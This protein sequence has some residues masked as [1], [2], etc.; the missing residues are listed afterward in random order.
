MVVSGGR[1]MDT[2]GAVLRSLDKNLSEQNCV[3]EL[4]SEG[5]QRGQ[6]IIVFCSSR[7][8]CEAT[9]RMLGEKADDVFRSSHAMSDDVPPVPIDFGITHQGCTHTL[10]TLRQERIACVRRLEEKCRE[11]GCAL[12]VAQD[13]LLLGLRRGV[14]FHHAG[15]PYSYSRSHSLID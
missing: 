14:A 6:Q 11:S 7:N 1:V 12:S 8:M 13:T 15:A 2:S 5:L 4:C 3:M 10:D 9:V